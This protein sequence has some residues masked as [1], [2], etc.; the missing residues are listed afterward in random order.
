M[1]SQRRRSHWTE[2]NFQIRLDL[3]TSNQSHATA[4]SI[5]LPL[6]AEHWIG[7]AE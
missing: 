2:T 4:I 6:I 3:L 7:L 5:T 1:N